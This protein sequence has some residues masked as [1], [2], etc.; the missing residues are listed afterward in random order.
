M[1]GLIIK[2]ALLAAAGLFSIGWLAV[3]IGQLGGPAGQLAKTYKLTAAFTDATGIVSGDEGRM[4]GVRIGKVGGLEVDRGRAIDQSAQLVSTLSARA[5]TIG[6]SIT[7]MADLL[8]TVAGHDDQVRQL[9][10]SMGSVSQAIAGKSADLGNAVASAGQF[11]G[12]L[13]RVL[14]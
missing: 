1:R 3:Q 11:T 2:L 13:A 5:S 8:D 10:G 6:S 4:A 7:Q 14:E 9:L 12:A